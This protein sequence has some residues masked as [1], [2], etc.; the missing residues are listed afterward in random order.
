M[1]I[2]AASGVPTLGLFGPSRE[3]LYGPWGPNCAHVRTPESFDRIHP[4]GFDHLT[5]ETLMDGLTV[6]TVIKALEVIWR[7]RREN[8]I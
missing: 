4:E 2:A 7:R 8:I 6:E 5:S 3:E 1:H